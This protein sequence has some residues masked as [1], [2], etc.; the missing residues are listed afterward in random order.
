MPDLQI[1]STDADDLGIT[2]EAAEITD[3]DKVVDV[4]YTDEAGYQYTRQLNVP[5]LADGSVDEY[6]L[7]Q[8]YN[9]QLAGVY[10]KRK[11]GLIEF[12][13]P[14]APEEED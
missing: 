4:T 9:G 13:G 12:K 10:N 2:Y 7:Q 5:R 11:V 14:N 8:I 1:P 6:E 3:T